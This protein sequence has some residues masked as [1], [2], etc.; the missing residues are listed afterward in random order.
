MS[1][2]LSFIAG[3]Q[4]LERR[5]NTWGRWGPGLRRDESFG[6]IFLRRI[7]ATQCTRL[8]FVSMIKN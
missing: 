2:S 3:P 7:G 6:A 8:E 5:Q 1:H 4:L